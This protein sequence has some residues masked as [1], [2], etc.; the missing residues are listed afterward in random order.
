MMDEIGYVSFCGC[1]SI[2]IRSKEQIGIVLKN[3]ED[4]ARVRSHFNDKDFVFEYTTLCRNNYIDVI[5]DITYEIGGMISLKKVK[6]YEDFIL[7]N[8]IA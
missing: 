2:V 6:K 4:I 8:L 7:R 1:D 3:S 5:E